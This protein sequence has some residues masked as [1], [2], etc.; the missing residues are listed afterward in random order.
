MTEE[1]NRQP[2]TGIELIDSF[3]KQLNE[4]K[5]KYLSPELIESMVALYNAGKLTQTNIA[6]SLDEIR[7]KTK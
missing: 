5:E 2:K 6:N 3:F 7:E 4:D 1:H